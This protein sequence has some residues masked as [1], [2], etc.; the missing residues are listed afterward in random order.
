MT[1][2]NFRIKFNDR[3]HRLILTLISKKWVGFFMATW[4]LIHKF[5]P[6]EIW[7]IAFGI[8]VGG[9]ITQKKLIG[10]PNADPTDTP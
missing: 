10:A 5:I 2:H 3:C 4:L 1:D 9:D 6:A 8:A 7:V